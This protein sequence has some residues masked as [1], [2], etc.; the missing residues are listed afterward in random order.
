MPIVYPTCPAGNSGNFSP[1]LQDGM[2]EPEVVSPLA[3]AVGCRVWYC[4]CMMR[5]TP[6]ASNPM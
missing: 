2:V 3:M 1:I 4:L 5:T 6:F